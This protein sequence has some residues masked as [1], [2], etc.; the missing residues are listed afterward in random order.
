MNVKFSSTRPTSRVIYCP[1]SMN[2]Y[3]IEGDSEGD[4]MSKF[5]V[6]RDFLQMYG[7]LY[8]AIVITSLFFTLLKYK[9]YFFIYDT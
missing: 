8:N 3:S 1:W 2:Q 5:R 4:K 9:L 6:L 7:F